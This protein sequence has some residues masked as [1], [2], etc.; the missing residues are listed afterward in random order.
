MSFN[1]SSVTLENALRELREVARQEKTNLA[2]WSSALTGSVTALWALDVHTNIVNA[3][4][5]MDARASLTGMSA[6]AQAQLGSPTY[7]IAAEY[8]TMK[9]A[10]LAVRDWL[11]SNIPSN[12]LTVTNAAI[13]PATYAPASTASLRSLID[14]AALTIA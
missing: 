9:N 4:A 3:L 2:A 8:S 5:F 6:Y 10:L 11:R 7:D 13:V 14:A 1:A 12:A